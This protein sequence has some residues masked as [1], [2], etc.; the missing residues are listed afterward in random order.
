M[1]DLHLS[2]DEGSGLTQQIYDQLR[3]AILTGRLPAGTRLPSSR[4]LAQSLGVA[5]NTVTAALDHLVAEGYLQAR[6][7]V[8]T[9]VS[10]D[11]D[12][13]A[14]S[15]QRPR[16]S[17][18]T[19]A[20]LWR[21]GSLQVPV[22]DGE[23][24]AYD[25]R[26]GLPDDS[27][28]PYPA[29][30]R[31]VDAVVRRSSRYAVYAGPA[32]PAVLRAAIARH[33]GVSRGLSV[34]PDDLLVTDGVQQAL[35]LLGQVLVEP[36]DVV[37]VEDPGYPP[38]RRAFEFARATV[39]PV[40][41]DEQ[42]IVVDRLPAR[43]TAVYVTPAHQ[44]P[45]GVRMSLARRTALLE[46]AR[47]AGAAVIEDDYDT[48]FR[49]GARPI[50]PLHV[51]DDSGRVIY[52]GSFSKSLLPA[53]R[54]GYCL[55]PPAVLDALLRARFVAGWHGSS[56]TQLALGGFIDDGQLAAHLRRMRR[57]YEQRRDRI[58]MV[59]DRSF[60]PYLR[61]IPTVAGLHLAARCTGADHDTVAAWVAA[62]A[63]EGVAIGSVGDY[64]LGEVEPGV[65]LGFGA[66]PLGR[67]D[68]G[69]DRL[70]AVIRS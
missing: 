4:E 19:P 20:R 32:G 64:A 37:A 60:H 52:V 28:F 3:G 45:L 9:F 39:V 42:G 44:F 29:W 43:A 26:T 25:F 54:V 17:P 68:A 24:P 62:C 48:D 36:G 49:Y 46:W 8:G 12:P 41:V 66:I 35:S 47:A 61:P 53:L 51:L 55:A 58:A 56:L 27:R 7:G 38:A 67:I 18:L 30:R 13:A 70:R 6:A 15:A 57:E 23:P 31:H 63:K 59:L 14:R 40:P 16:P 11:A 50:D 69:L 21:G 65:V 34:G 1:V 22:L 2:L 33:L 10:P 5:R